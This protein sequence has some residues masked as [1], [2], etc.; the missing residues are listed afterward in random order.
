MIRKNVFILLL[1]FSFISGCM[2]SPK[3]DKNTNRY[4]NDQGN[5]STEENAGSKAGKNTDL[6]PGNNGSSPPDQD[7]GEQK[8]FPLAKRLAQMAKDGFADKYDLKATLREVDGLWSPQKNILSNSKNLFESQLN[9]EAVNN[10]F[11]VIKNI[12]Q[13]YHFYHRLDKG[14]AFANTHESRRPFTY[15]YGGD[16]ISTEFVE[17]CFHAEKFYRYDN[18]TLKDAFQFLVNKKGNQNWGDFV[19]QIRNMTNNFKDKNWWKDWDNKSIA[20]MANIHAARFKAEPE[21]FLALLSTGSNTI[22]VENSGANDAN[23][24]NGGNKQ[25]KNHLGLLYMFHRQRFW[26]DFKQNKKTNFNPQDKDHVK[27]MLEW[28]KKYDGGVKPNVLAK[29]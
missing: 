28:L 13:A 9:E 2:R 26:Y 25:G 10:I 12:Q 22:I 20:V 18:K 3:E 14:G 23:W 24:G 7:K 5:K 6:M 19:Q 16:T 15:G 1:S 29:K 11:E 27:F 8:N 17:Y 4:K 21:L